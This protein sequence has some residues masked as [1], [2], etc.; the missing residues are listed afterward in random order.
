MTK[1]VTLAIALALVIAGAGTRAL[2]QSRE[3]RND[4]PDRA[5]AGCTEDIKR[6]TANPAGAGMLPVYFALRAAAYEKKDMLKEAK[7]DLDT[8]V[9][10]QPGFRAYFNRA[11]FSSN[12]GSGAETL[13]DYKSAIAAYEGEMQK[14]KEEEPYYA[15]ANF[16]VGEML[17]RQERFDEALP[18]YNKAVAA[19]P[20]DPEMLFNR[21]LVH[22]RLGNNEA[23]IDDLTKVVDKE[24]AHYVSGLM[25]RGAAYLRS[26]NLALAI[27]DMDKAVAKEPQSPLARVRRALVLERMGNRERAVAD[28]REALKLYAG[29]TEAQEGLA[30]LAGR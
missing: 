26:G 4:N 9:L 30:R 27:A 5:I 21:A 7:A 29:M 12:Y 19:K 25:N 3:C 6:A 17:R 28:Y 2:S 16:Q 1:A 20:G 8:A 15:Q 14:D 22:S 24:G 10:L 18:S 11:V 23:V 13:A